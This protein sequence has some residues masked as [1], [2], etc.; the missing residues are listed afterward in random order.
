[1]CTRKASAETAYCTSQGKDRQMYQG[2][3]AVMAS[4]AA[5]CCLLTVGC[6][7]T[8]AREQ[9]SRSRDFCFDWK[10]FN[11]D[12][13]EAYQPAF[14]DAHWTDVHL[15][16]DLS[17]EEFKDRTNPGRSEN[18]YFAGGVGWYRKHFQLSPQEH[19][20][21][22]F[23]LFDGVYQNSEVWINGHSLGI[24]PYGYIS[25]QH[26]LTPY[27]N[28][29]GDNVLAVRVN[30]T[31]QPN[32]RWYTGSGIYRRVWMIV[33]DKL[34]V[35]SWGTSITTP[36]VEP[37]K[38]YVRIAAE[39]EN[40]Y[41]D[42]QSCTLTTVI[43]DPQ[44]KVAAECASVQRIPAESGFQIEQELEVRCPQLWSIDSP[45]MY[46]ARTIVRN[47]SGMCDQY[48]TPFGIRRIAFDKDKGFLL[49]GKPVKMKGVCLHHDAGCLGAAVPV[50][51][52]QRRLEILKSIGCNA[53]RTSHNPPAP[54]LLD[55]CDRMG[56]VVIDEA[57]DKWEG[58][59]ARSFAEWWQ[60]DLTD[61][62]RRDRN[63]PSVVM[64]SVGNEVT[65]QGSTK[66]ME[67]LKRMADLAR[68]VDPT[69]PVTCALFPHGANP[70]FIAQIADIV[71][72]VSCNYM[73]QLFED[74]RRERPD[75][76]LAA[77]ES[78][79]YYRGEGT[80]I[81]AFVPLNPWLEVEQ[82]DYVVG[83]FYWAGID[84]LGE[85]VAGWPYH[86]WNC[87]LI[88]TCGFVR[89]IANL[90]KSFWI[91]Q[92]MVHIA[93]M[94]DSLDV[95]K[96]VKEHW[97][98]P[99]TDSHWNLSGQ[100]GRQVKVATFTNCSAVE[101]FV[102]AKPLGRK[103]LKDF[104]DKMITWMVPYEPGHIE[105]RGLEQGRT[106]CDH[107]LQ[108]AGKPA[109]IRLLADRRKIYADGCDVSHV[110]V[111]IVDEQGILVPDA[112]SPIQFNIQGAGRIIGVDNGDLTSME[113]YKADRRK[114][115][116]GRA[117]VIVQ[118]LRQ[119]GS[120]TLK[121]Q[122]AG[123]PPAQMILFAGR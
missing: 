120:I 33:T 35:R 87:C 7:M 8:T 2:K 27:V 47:E 76:I 58:R 6:R 1:M 67:Q 24:R 75:V 5:V 117:L 55:L 42:A 14:D 95:P 112:D 74:F 68:R 64:W 46:I 111:Q 119:P 86:G 52:L 37:D 10:F 99:K 102:N 92:P 109:R 100:E 113:P 107:Y 96:P 4:M 116:H 82:H 9:I 61:M 45:A 32:C 19:G 38:T 29:D 56:F 51:V 60:T 101:L 11:G 40:A 39:L 43:L 108:T 65:V 50:R 54:E 16:H 91:D 123:L 103:E 81:K 23:I 104:P 62:I 25:F 85:A 98:W 105:A 115:F 93:V 28:W 44:G 121:A 110:E 63:H 122:T 59:Y 36:H 70:A 69:R 13:A 18:G 53:I 22:V 15:P 17:I 77:S 34:Y 89:P 31:D 41:A 21:K 57:F 118:S 106:V 84:Y 73:E 97:D 90:V 3:A 114:T 30:N 66:F 94:D 72:V 83:G 78:F 26:D 48:D 12:A 49:N 20:Q 71:D 80:N 88:D 79:P